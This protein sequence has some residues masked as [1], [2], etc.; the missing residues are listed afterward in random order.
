[1][2][3]KKLWCLEYEINPVSCLCMPADSVFSF[4]FAAVTEVGV[5][6]FFI[7]SI[8]CSVCLLSLGSGQTGN[9]RKGK[10]LSG[11]KSRKSLQF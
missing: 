11:T 8:L 3:K 4:A 5:S 9:P 2:T 10:L 6:A 1:M 7:G